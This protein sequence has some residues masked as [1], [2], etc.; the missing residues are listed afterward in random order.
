MN[1][2]YSFRNI[3][4]RHFI[5]SSMLPIL[6]LFC[7]LSFYYNW[8]ALEFNKDVYAGA[9]DAGA[10][11]LNMS[12]AELEQISFTPYLYTDI[13]RMMT[14]MKN[15]YLEAGVEPP[16]YLN[17]AQLETNYTLLFTKLLHASA[18]D[19]RSIRFY[20]FGQGRGA[21]YSINRDTAGLSH[22]Q[23]SW[24]TVDTLYSYTVPYGSKAVFLGLDGAQDTGGSFLLLRTIKDYD[25]GKELGIL[26]IE[27][28]TSR[29]Y[30]SLD[31][32]NIT[33]NSGL[34]LTDQTGTVVYS[35]GSA[36][37]D[38]LAQAAGSSAYV[39]QDCTL[40][41]AGWQLSL[42][43]SV[44]DF[45]VSTAESVAIIFVV[46]ALAFVA[47]F[48]LY[49]FQ[50]ASA[51]VSIDSILYAIRQLQDGNLNYTCKV[52]GNQDFQA[53]ADALNQTG[54]K[55]DALIHTEAEARASQSRAE[56]LALQSQINPHFLYNVLNGFIALNR[57]GERQLLESSI[58]HLTKLFRY[59]CNNDD[60]T[61]VAREYDFAVQYLELQKLRFG[62]QITY[63][64]MVD[65]AVADIRI[66]KLVVQPFVENCIVHGM[67]ADDTP[68]EIILHSMLRRE[69][70]GGQTLILEIVDTG[71][72]YDTA[73]TPPG[74][75]LTNVM[76]RLSIFHE[77]S[78][79]EIRSTPGKGT[80]VRILLEMNRETT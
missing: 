58:L 28:G 9:L 80:T 41:R 43:L 40:E 15:G 54:Q 78:H 21:C 42:I 24:Q 46:A 39:V 48:V 59:I 20:P 30:D 12:F 66:P 22:T 72:G 36:T 38:L 14:Y 56:Y 53:I 4:L 11:A 76:Q 68:I 25:S 47:G 69:E 57:M 50:S 34:L 71:V 35:A 63:T 74:V 13:S 75:G 3:S 2:G 64:V 61:T 6:A 55:L 70:N 27:A 73:S 26:E 67:E 10:S 44:D 37:P 49:R 23:V 77:R 65:P 60:T 5:I 32:I 62:D 33:Q 31:R 8:K 45:R 16:D 51:V 17:L 19:V 52:A 7:A 18:Q 29:I 1:M 79:Y